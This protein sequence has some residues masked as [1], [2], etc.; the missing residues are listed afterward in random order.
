MAITPHDEKANGAAAGSFAPVAVAPG[1]WLVCGVAVVV[2]AGVA[3]AGVC[4]ACGPTEP[5]KEGVH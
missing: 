4:A 1:V 3:L 5:V 2:L